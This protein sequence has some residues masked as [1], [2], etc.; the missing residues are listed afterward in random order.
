MTELDL[1]AKQAHHWPMPA[2]GFRRAAF[3]PS[4]PRRQHGVVLVVALVL[5]VLISLLAITSLRNAGSSEN[6]AG[7]ARTTELAF[8]AANI[9]LR[10]CEASVLE[11]QK[12]AYRKNL[13]LP[14]E[15]TYVTTFT[16]ANILPATYP[17]AWKKMANWDNAPTAAFVLL[18]LAVKENAA[19]APTY[20]REP[21]C[22][23]EELLA[24]PAGT[25]KLYI[26]TARGFG[27]EVA[28]VDSARTPPSG[29]EVWLQSHIEIE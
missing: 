29:S 12:N 16:A 20:S 24:T 13:N 4:P 9:A 10:H 5:L 8:Q 3:P 7:N 15:E 2:A 25:S 23:V 18:P 17:P 26:V 27:P 19:A 11:I 22:M 1:P 21:E 6:I 14:P 28:K